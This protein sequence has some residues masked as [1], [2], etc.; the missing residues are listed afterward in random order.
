MRNHHLHAMLLACIILIS[1]GCARKN[2]FAK[3]PVADKQLYEQ[4][5]SASPTDVDSVTIQAG[6]HYQRSGF[7]NIIWGKH[8]RQVW[9]APVMVKVFDMNQTKGGLSIKKLGGGMQT[10]SLTLA[11]KDGFT[12][13]LRSLDKDPAGILPKFWRNTFV[14]NVLR[15]QTSAIN[16][17]AAI[18]L[19]TM[20][21]AAGIPHSK[22]ELVYVLPSDNTFGEFSDKFQDGV[23]MIEEKYNDDR[24]ITPMLG[25]A[26]DIASSKKMLKNRF[27]DNDHFIDQYAFAR[28]RLFDL[29]INDWDRHEGQWEWAVYDKGDNK[30]YRAIPKD[31]DNAFFQFD[32]GIM[33]WLF[34]RNW[35]IRKFESFDKEYK[36][37]YALMMNASFIDNRALTELTAQDYQEIAKELQAA[38]TDEVI[39][40][41]IR[42]FPPSVYK[43]V[44][45]K[46]INTLKSRRDKLPEAAHQFYLHLAKNPL[47]IG[48]DKEERFEVKRLNND[49]TSVTVV[50]LSDKQQVFHRV[51]KNKET[52][53]ITLHGLAD[54]DEFEVSGEVKEG[55]RVVIVGGRGEDKIKDTSRVESWRRKTIVYDTKRGNQLELGPE[56]VDKTSRNV[57]VHAFDREGH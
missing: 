34:S 56:T 26:T 22:P 54:D 29:F 45:E 51:Y 18:V 12:Y 50:R 41:A 38:L 47:V 53:S 13:A 11:D 10:T 49:E 37:V 43:Q 48:T 1:S 15:D 33:T 8:Y 31:R 14:A 52:K 28:A 5:K 39:E 3:T 2:F 55:I 4:L 19:P 20:A 21:E 35:A 23:F 17:Y 9:A 16:P 6:R 7:R 42:Q 57:K 27:G 36:D 46:T 30:Y 24:S 40:K 25:N 44:G 32:D